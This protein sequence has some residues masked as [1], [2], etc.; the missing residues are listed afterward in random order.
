MHAIHGNTTTKMET[1]IETTTTTASPTPT[2]PAPKTKA[3]NAKSKAA[4]KSKTGPG[5]PPKVAA[6]S[7]A[8]PRAS[9]KPGKPKTAKIVTLRGT[10][11]ALNAAMDRA[12]SEEDPSKAMATLWGY[13]ALRGDK[14]DEAAA[15]LLVEVHK[16]I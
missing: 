13:C 16:M 12:W 9:A 3:A 4:P 7:V 14:L 8:K 2:T 1:S 15:G 10:I 6:K 5:R 11:F